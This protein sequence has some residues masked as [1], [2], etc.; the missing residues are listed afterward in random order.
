MPGVSRA[1]R[2]DEVDPRCNLW[3]SR[4]PWIQLGAVRNQRA[5][6]HK[7]RFFR[8]RILSKFPIHLTLPLISRTQ[9]AEPP[10]EVQSLFDYSCFPVLAIQTS[11]PND[12]TQQS[13]ASLGGSPK[14]ETMR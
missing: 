2:T 4:L 11:T 7:Q 10:R 8:R 6:E 12:A 5:V 9:K 3:I 13:Q 14:A 1:S